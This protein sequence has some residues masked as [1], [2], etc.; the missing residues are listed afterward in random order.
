MTGLGSPV[1]G[2][3]PA[4]AS[5]WWGVLSTCSSPVVDV[6]F[7][8]SVSGCGGCRLRRQRPDRQAANWGPTFT[9]TYFRIGFIGVRHSSGIPEMIHFVP[10]TDAS[11]LRFA[12]FPLRHRF[13]AKQIHTTV[14]GALRAWAGSFFRSSHP[15]GEK[16]GG[17]DSPD[18]RLFSFTSRSVRVVRRDDVGRD[19]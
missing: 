19:E 17:A 16:T 9:R 4:G 18:I 11:C 8:M 6:H 2:Q 10:R 15:G 14:F 3:V 1:D 7:C 13:R 12:V 5:C